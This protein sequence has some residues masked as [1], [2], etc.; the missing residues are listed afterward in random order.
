MSSFPGL[1]ACLCG[2]SLAL[3]QEAQAAPT[4]IPRTSYAVHYVDSQE[5]AGENGA[6]VRAIDGNTSTYWS[7]EWKNAQPVHP[8]EFQLD[9]G[10]ARNVTG[11]RYLPRQGSV[12]NGRIAQFEF[13]TSADG[14]NWGSPR[15]TGT[16]PNSTAQQ[17]VLFAPVQAR[18]VRLRALSEVA[19]R[20]FTTVAELGVLEEPPASPLFIPQAG[21]TVHFVDGQE[22]TGENG[23]AVRAFDG[24]ANTFWSSQWSPAIAPL[25]HEL[26]INLGSTFEVAGFRYTPR[27]GSTSNGRIAQYEF[28]TSTDGTSWGAPA[29]AGTWSNTATSQTVTFTSRPARFV[30]LRALSEVA[31]R[32][33]TTVAE[34]NVLAG[35]GAA[36]QAPESTITSPAN[37]VAITTGQSVTFAGTGS[38]PDGNAPLSYRWFFGSGSGI[39]DATTATPGAVQFNTPGTY[40]V[41]FTV[42]DSLGLADPTPA[43]RTIIVQSPSVA[44]VPRT[45]WALHYVDSQELAGENGAATR[46][47]DGNNNTYWTTQWSPSAAAY[48]HELQINLGGV[49]SLRGF[50][51]LPRQGTI[52]N[53]RIAQFEFYVSSDGV[54]WGSPVAAGTWPNSAAQQEVIFPAKVGQYIRLRALSEVAG[55]AFAAVAELNAL[56]DGVINQAPNGTISSPG[57][58]VTISAGSTVSFAGSGLDPDGH[59][60]LT[61]LWHFGAGSGV[62][63]STQQNPG[64][65]Q[66]NTAG[67]YTVSLTVTDSNGLSDATPA[68]RVITVEPAGANQTT[69][70]P[71]TKATVRSVDSQETTGENGA[72]VNAIDGSA[73]T[74]WSSRWSGSVAPLP[75]EIEIDLGYGC[76]VAGF[77][78]LPRQD[79]ISNG[80]IAQY[81][82]YVSGDGVNWGSPVATGTFANTA[83][84]KQVLFTA[85]AGRYVRLRALSEV[86]GRSLTTVA[87]LNVLE[88]E[89]IVPSVRLTTPLPYHFQS[90][91][92]LV[93]H[94]D[95]RLSSGQGLR[96]SVDGIP[97]MVDDYSAPYSATFTN[98]PLAEH[99]VRAR[100]ITASGTVVSGVG[101][102]DV[103]TNVAVGEYYVGFGDSITNGSHDTIPSDNIS[104]DTRNATRGFTPLLSNLLTTSRGHPVLV[105]NEGVSGNT[106]ADGL[107][108]IQAILQK[109][110]QSQYFLVMFGTND[111]YQGVPSGL[112]LSP[113]NAGYV[114]SFKDRMQQIINAIVAAGKQPILARAPV[115]LPIN[116]TQDQRQQQYNQVVL[117]LVAA[118]AISVTPPDFYAYFAATHP[119][120]YDDHI[121]PNGVGY[122]SMADIWDQALSP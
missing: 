46:A 56:H 122:Q 52:S 84:E 19:G 100:V 21:W 96:F 20:V 75:H 47:F 16:W 111:A 102:E 93:V 39:P 40:T 18:Y 66:F 2:F 63:N 110:P 69:T 43:T 64:F 23:S 78:Y 86:A 48:P 77:R 41:S 8:H 83:A 117:E 10:S 32:Q 30:R 115:W 5:T 6:A 4:L 51:Y 89:R 22:T 105:A 17:E 36:N 57:S 27:Q 37:N 116:G 79:G 109:H 65:I 34:L 14:L 54:N 121:H 3:P 114:N 62:S 55:R 80:N 108:R 82:F 25:P 28:Y 95:P 71:R 58:H 38:D 87:E 107:A 60:P 7:T 1:L 29:A 9:L 103:N 31:G 15:A 44:V 12:S 91:T 67:T 85:K 53:G 33:L 61:Y 88:G 68:T 120:E 50:R 92:S 99:T 70:V 74:F 59:T 106:A 73:S 76:N 112:G 13:Y 11:F 26:Q 104:A 113:G 119:T 72:A 98:L 118:N 94:A 49:Y 42:T 45:N 90:S 81:E 101:A 97:G 24:D 35:S